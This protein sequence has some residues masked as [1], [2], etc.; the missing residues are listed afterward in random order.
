MF[1]SFAFVVFFNYGTIPSS[2]KNISKLDKIKRKQRRYYSRHGIAKI[3]RP[4]NATPHKQKNNNNIS[5]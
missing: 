5:K 1:F 3:K 2:S 4:Q